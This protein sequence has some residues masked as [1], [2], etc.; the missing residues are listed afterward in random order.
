[1]FCGPMMDI[2]AS[3]KDSVPLG[4]TVA[5]LTSMIATAVFI[6]SYLLEEMSESEAIYFSIITGESNPSS[7]LTFCWLED[8]MLLRGI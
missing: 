6:F 1:M 8:S 5:L 7:R 2:A 4:G 3:W